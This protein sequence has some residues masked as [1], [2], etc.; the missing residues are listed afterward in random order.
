[1]RHSEQAR[2][3]QPRN[4]L[5]SSAC[6]ILTGRQPRAWLAR[7]KTSGRTGRLLNARRLRSRERSSRRQKSQSLQQED[8]SLRCPAPN[9][10]AT[11]ALAVLDV[12]I[13]P[14]ILQAAV[15]EDAVDKHTLVKND[16]L[17]FKCSI[18][19]SSHKREPVPLL[20]RSGIPSSAMLIARL[21]LQEISHRRGEG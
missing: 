5:C 3:R 6:S 16:V 13:A 1:M 17:I 18:F 8:S 15:L 14:R 12:Y 19:E 11:L 21:P 9:Q 4:P 7:G 10:L 20:M 2:D